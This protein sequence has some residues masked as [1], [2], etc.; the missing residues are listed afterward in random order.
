MAAR[1]PRGPGLVRL[2]VATR[3]ESPGAVSGPPA[4]RESADRAG[5]AGREGA[6][7]RRR[8]GGEGSETEIPV[9]VRRA[10]G[11]EAANEA[12]RGPR[13]AGPASATPTDPDRNGGRRGVA[14]RDPTTIAGPPAEG[15]SEGRR[16]SEAGRNSGRVSRG[17]TP[18]QER[19]GAGKACEIGETTPAGATGRGGGRE[20]VRRTPTPDPPKNSEPIDLRSGE[21]TRWI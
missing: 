1:A 18:A 2:R 16:T 8:P 11:A 19:G 6:E 9:V 17:R 14:S 3:Q 20:G 4:G 13:E 5:P 15:R 21:R 7:A 10:G 12:R